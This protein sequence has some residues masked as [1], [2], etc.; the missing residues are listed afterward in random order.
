MNC[1]EAKKTKIFAY[2][3]F[4]KKSGKLCVGAN[5]LSTLKKRAYL[6]LSCKTSSENARKEAEKFAKSA[7]C[8]LYDSGDYTL[9]ELLLKDDCKTAAVTDPSLA[10]AI[11]SVAGEYGLK[12]L[13]G[14]KND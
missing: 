4:A 8:P 3:G 13:S 6:A 12:L 1:L 9:E 5:S 7:G 10:E 11:I 2:L 14:G